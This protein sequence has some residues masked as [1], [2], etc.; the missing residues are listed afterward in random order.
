MNKLANKNIQKNAKKLREIKQLAET[1]A[2][3]LESQT[4]SAEVFIQL[5]TR[6]I[7]RHDF[8]QIDHLANILH[9]RFSVSEIA[10]VVRQANLPHIQAL[11]Y[12]TLVLKPVSSLLPLLDDP[13][14][15]DIIQN[16]LEQQ[17]FEF[18]N[19]EAQQILA[20]ID[21]DEYFDKE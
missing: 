1:C 11:G 10:E 3:V 7:V 20:M 8:E 5:A 2:G 13:I 6:A 18:D 12:E 15:N 21:L 16:V 4:E 19:E 17:A 14:Y 9:E